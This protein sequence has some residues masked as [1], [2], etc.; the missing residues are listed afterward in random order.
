MAAASDPEALK[1]FG[2]L[3]RVVGPAQRASTAPGWRC[4]AQRSSC[5][6]KHGQAATDRPSLSRRAAA[7]P[8]ANPASPENMHVA[9]KSKQ[10]LEILSTDN[11]NN[12][13][14][15]AVMQTASTAT[16]PA[17]CSGTASENGVRARR[18]ASA[19]SG[20][21]GPLL[22]ASR[23]CLPPTP[24][25]PSSRSWTRPPRRRSKAGCP[26][27]GGARGRG[28]GVLRRHGPLG[29]PPGESG[30][31]PAHV[32]P[33]V[34]MRAARHGAPGEPEGPTVGHPVLRGATHRRC[35][36][37]CGAPAAP[38]QRGVY[39]ESMAQTARARPAGSAPPPGRTTGTAQG[40]GP[41]V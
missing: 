9:A 25:V 4:T 28:R 19:L 36:S 1:T 41:A 22:V 31:G 30:G 24:A 21:S 7:W 3:G 35:S 12:N 15:N 17:A 20:R 11:M 10:R 33:L 32:P 40:R 26:R 14:N 16:A 13:N 38:S 23:R 18:I 6:D 27:V 39:G 37:R 5:I 8:I 2:R 29:G 34:C